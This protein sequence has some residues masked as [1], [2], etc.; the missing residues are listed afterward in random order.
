MSSAL[1]KKRPKKDKNAPKKC[2]TAYIFYTEET[3]NVLRV[4]NPEATF[5]ELSKLAGERWKGLDSDEKAKFEALAA[6][7]KERYEEEMQFYVPPDPESEEMSA[8]PLSDMEPAKGKRRKKP[9]KDKNAPKGALSAYF[10]YSAE[11]RDQIREEHP[12]MSLGS[13]AKMIGARWREL[14]AEEKAAYEEKSK[15]DK[16]RYMIEMTNYLH[17]KAAGVEIMSDAQVEYEDDDDDEEDEDDEEDD[18]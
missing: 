8:H 14:S 13:I 1:G 5:G 2:R 18:D 9:K 15:R 12:E 10:V 3:R 11:L 7:D 17:A 6:K 16:E 4:Q